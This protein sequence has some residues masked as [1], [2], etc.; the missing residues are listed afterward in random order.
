MIL[1]NIN[2]GSVSEVPIYKGLS[3]YF[4]TCRKVG[5]DIYHDNPN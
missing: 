3:K 1:T 2:N 4:T 5:R